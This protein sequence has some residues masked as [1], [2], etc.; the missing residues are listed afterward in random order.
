[1]F[2]LDSFF[3]HVLD[4]FNYIKHIYIYCTNCNSCFNNI[5]QF[6]HV[7]DNQILK[8]IGNYI[9]DGKTLNVFCKPDV[10]PLIVLINITFSKCIKRNYTYIYMYI[11]I[12][13]CMWCLHVYIHVYCISILI[14]AF[15][16]YMYI[17]ILYN[18]CKP[19]M[20]LHNLFICTI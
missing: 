20:C 17:C 11:H 16:I 10:I 2:S 6:L 19:C 15:L 3:M 7:H 9:T 5:T 4:N 1:M 8:I 12:N 18:D 13:T 14:L